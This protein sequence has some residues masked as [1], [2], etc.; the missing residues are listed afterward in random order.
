MELNRITTGEPGA[1][2]PVIL[3]H[4]LFG[5]ARNLGGLARRLEGRRRVQVDMRNHGDSPWSDDHSYPA[6]ADDLAR[7]IEAEGGV[8]DVVGH[9]MGGKAAMALS[10]MHPEKVRRLVVLDIAPVAYNHSQADIAAAAQSVDLAAVERRSDADRLL[11]AAGVEDPGTR[12]FLLQSLEVRPDARARWRM[13]LDVLEG[14]MDGLTG[15][16]E[17]ALTPGAFDG[18]VLALHGA[19]S[20]YVSDK[21]RAGF[22]RWFPQA[23]LRRVE[24]CGH[25]LH[26]ERP[27]AVGDAV[28]GF[29]A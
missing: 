1:D 12:A 14:A 13:N 22:G 7:V 11:A 24:G 27:E 20:S 5:A 18:P 19:N 3:A 4:G 26:A 23:E 29:L 16:P 9:S 15:W 25:W 8:A 21:G 28:A 6:L 2:P 10:L 17:E